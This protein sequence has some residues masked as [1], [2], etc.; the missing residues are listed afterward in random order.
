MAVRIDRSLRLPES[1][2]FPGAQRKT[3]IAIHHT[4]GGTAES[5]FRWWRAKQSHVGT[6]YIVERDGTVYEVFDPA[7]WAYQFGLDWDPIARI[8]FEKR[9]IG[10]ELASEGGLTEHDGPLYCYDR[11]SPRQLKPKAEAFD[12]GEPYRGYRWFDR[13]EDAQLMSLGTLVNELCARFEIPRQYPDEPFEYYG[14]SLTRFEGVIGH[15]NVRPDKSDPAPDWRLWVMLEDLA[16]LRPTAAHPSARDEASKSLI[17]QVFDRSARYLNKMDVA[18]GSMVKALLMELER[19]FTVLVL[20]EPSTGAHRIGYHIM[21][22]E[23]K[24]VKSVARALG[25]TNVTSQTLEVRRA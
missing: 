17:M 11:V 18:A 6:A 15:A 2:Y 4:V 20:D 9:F 24:T 13:Y 23:G 10:I 25:F 3:G 21:V 7:G 1:Q 16:A 19:R 8:R 12:Y 22:G 14:E 5:T